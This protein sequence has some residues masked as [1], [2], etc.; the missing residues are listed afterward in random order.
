MTFIKI[1]KK[2]LKPVLILSPDFIVFCNTLPTIYLAISINYEPA[3]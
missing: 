3:H 1:K 2:C